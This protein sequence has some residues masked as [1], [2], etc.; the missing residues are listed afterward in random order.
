ME[1]TILYPH[2]SINVSDVAASIAFYKAFF[3]SEP[4]KVREGYAKFELQ[5]PKLNFTLNETSKPLQGEHILNHLGFQVGSTDDVLMMR[6]RLK[7]AGITTEDEM[8]TTCCYA[9]QDKIWI[10]DPNG[11]NWE[12]FVVLSD[13][14]SYRNTTASGGACC[15]PELVTL[16]AISA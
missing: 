5:N 7:Q 15:T 2:I 11:I 8:Q 4:I 3:G 1:T 13:A 10:K 14:D 12:V 9:V 16:E 6:L